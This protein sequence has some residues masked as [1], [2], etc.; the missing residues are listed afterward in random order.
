MGA[1]FWV[2]STVWW[3]LL[4]SF[5]FLETTGK[6]V[7][8]VE[9]RICF[10]WWKMVVQH[11]LN[12]FSLMKENQHLWWDSDELVLSWLKGWLS[13]KQS[14][15]PCMENMLP[16]KTYWCIN[17]C[18]FVGIIPTHEQSNLVE[19]CFF[20]LPTLW[21]KSVGRIDIS[22]FFFTTISFHGLNFEA[23]HR[24]RI[25]FHPSFPISNPKRSLS[26][27]HF[28]FFL[29]K[30]NQPP[31]TNRVSTMPI[32]VCEKTVS[33]LQCERW[34]SGIMPDAKIAK[35]RQAFFWGGNFHWRRDVVFFFYREAH[36]YRDGS[37]QGSNY[38]YAL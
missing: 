1:D 7:C 26:F 8:F 15:L 13:S 16:S 17:S 22:V 3:W 38:N 33:T 11:I 35:S 20:L 23:E 21:W 4:S 36:S 12:S 18:K 14:M 19:G 6:G 10:R 27:P 31:T 9:M 2:A 29:G 34:A 30:K 37:F 5:W 25:I 28:L 24:L 32:P